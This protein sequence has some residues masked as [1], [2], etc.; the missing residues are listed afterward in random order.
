M[1]VIKNDRYKQNA[2]PNTISTEVIS[3]TNDLIFFIIFF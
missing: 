1:F 2:K 3:D